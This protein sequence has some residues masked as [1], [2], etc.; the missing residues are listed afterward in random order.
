MILYVSLSCCCCWNAYALLQMNHPNISVMGKKNESKKTKNLHTH[1]LHIALKQKCGNEKWQNGT[2]G[3]PILVAVWKRRDK[4]NEVRCLFSTVSQSFVRWF[5]LSHRW[6]A[7]S[8]MLDMHEYRNI[9]TLCIVSKR[10]R[11]NVK[12]ALRNDSSKKLTCTKLLCD[13][14]WQWL[15]FISLFC[16]CCS[17]FLYSFFFFFSFI[18]LRLTLYP[19]GYT[20]HL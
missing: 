11:N 13:F 6:C 10:F 5:S 7:L 3:R 15:N 14:L 1:S 9:L 16:A 2:K 8:C 12:H 20:V 18:S 17:L 4:V 19:S